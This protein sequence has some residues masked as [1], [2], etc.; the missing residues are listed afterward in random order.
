MLSTFPTNCTDLVTKLQEQAR[1]ERYVHETYKNINLHISQKYKRK[2]ED[3]EEVII[4]VKAAMH[5]SI[6][7]S[8]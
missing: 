1:S 7:R 5:S 2:L 8:K 6:Y 4:E 3:T